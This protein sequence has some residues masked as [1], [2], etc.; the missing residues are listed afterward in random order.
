M[1]YNF[2]WGAW[3]RALSAAAR[4]RALSPPGKSE[5]ARARVLWG[6]GEPPIAGPVFSPGYGG[7]TPT[8]PQD[9][10]HFP[11]QFPPV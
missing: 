7:Q 6:L 11:A 8:Q 10:R 2:S 3:N 1:L 9:V 5:P 4:G